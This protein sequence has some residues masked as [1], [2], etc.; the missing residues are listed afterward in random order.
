MAHGILVGHL[1][2]LDHVAPAE[3][4]GVQPKL[5]RCRIHQAFNDVDRLRPPGAAI[6][7]SGCGIGQHGGELEINI[8]DVVDAGGNPRPNQQLNGD[9]CVACVAAQIGQCAHA[10]AEYLAIGIQRQFHLAI[11]IAAMQRG[12]EIFHP[13]RSP[14][15][16]AAQAPRCE[17]HHGI[18]GI[19]PGFHAKAAADITHQNAHA[20]SWNIQNFLAKLIPKA[21]G[22]LRA[23][24]DGEAITCAIIIRQHHA[25]FHGNRRQALID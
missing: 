12:K 2:W 17:S 21:G 10:K 7:A 6:R 14:F 24:A 18:F 3:F 20:V 19:K 8:R 4:G 15:H 22:H 23:H 13:L 5:A 11:R 1:F 16:R 9:T 25:R